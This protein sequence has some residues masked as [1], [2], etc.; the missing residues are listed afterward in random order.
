MAKCHRDT[1]M[2]HIHLEYPIY[3]WEH[4]KGYGTQKHLDGLRKYGILDIHR[5]TFGICKEFS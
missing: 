1:Y 3:D 5:K 2:K 4:N